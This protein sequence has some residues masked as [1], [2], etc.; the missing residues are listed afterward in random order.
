MRGFYLHIPLSPHPHLSLQ[1]VDHAFFHTWN[2]QAPGRV[3]G[4]A[5]IFNHQ[6]FKAIGVWVEAERGR[7]IVDAALHQAIA[8][9]D[10]QGYVGLA[11]MTYDGTGMPRNRNKACDLW[12]KG[13]S[14]GDVNA[15]DYS[16]RYCRY[17]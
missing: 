10:S 13:S 16:K 17:R 15:A 1:A 7:R 8:A 3:E 14:L 2:L 5:V 9:G 4:L 6:C 11:I 12:Q